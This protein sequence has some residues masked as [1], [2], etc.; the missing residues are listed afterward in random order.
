ARHHHLAAVAG[1]T[2]AAPALARAAGFAVASLDALSHDGS[3]PGRRI[4][5]RYSRDM[6]PVGHGRGCSSTARPLGVYTK[7]PRQAAARSAQHSLPS[8]LSPGLQLI[9]RDDPHAPQT[10]Q[11]EMRLHIALKSI[12]AHA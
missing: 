4:A 10:D 6:P 3:P 8:P 9:H 7:L 2:V 12:K 11:R 5:S 1:G